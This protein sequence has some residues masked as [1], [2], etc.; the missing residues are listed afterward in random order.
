MEASETPHDIAFCAH[1]IFQ[2]D[3][4]VVQDALNDVRFAAMQALA[5]QV[6]AQLELRRNLIEREQ[7]EKVLRL[8]DRAMAAGSNGITISGLTQLGNPL[9]YCNLAF[10]KE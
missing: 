3:L 7:I 1:A 10:I 5:R 8:Q 2:P 4:F 9:I 6:V